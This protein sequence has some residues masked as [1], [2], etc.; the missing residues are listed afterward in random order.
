MFV[1]KVH[2]INGGLVMV[3]SDYR[4]RVARGG[5]LPGRQSCHVVGLKGGGHGASLEGRGEVLLVVGGVASQ[6][7]HTATEQAPINV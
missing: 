6:S 4:G 5:L 2:K 7:V 1:G 3:R